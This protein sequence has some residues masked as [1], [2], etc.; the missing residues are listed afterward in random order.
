MMR[1]RMRSAILP[2]G[3]MI[4]LPCPAWRAHQT[5]DRSAASARK[6]VSP[7]Y[8]DQAPV[9]LSPLDRTA[10]RRAPRC[11][12]LPALPAA[13]PEDAPRG[14]VPRPGYRAS[15]RPRGCAPLLPSVRRPPRCP[16]DGPV[17]A[18][19]APVHGDARTGLTPHPGADGLQHLATMLLPGC[20]LLVTPQAVPVR[21]APRDRRCLGIPW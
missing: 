15:Q 14:T 8:R 20:G 7:P 12:V 19:A 6:S 3:L 21:G 13:P 17:P 18:T 2:L 5:W 10:G 16:P 4:P 9:R 1:L 11:G